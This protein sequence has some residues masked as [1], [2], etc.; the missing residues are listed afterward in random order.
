MKNTFNK[1][2]IIVCTPE[3]LLCNLLHI[4]W[5]NVQNYLII[6]DKGLFFID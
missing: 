5:S 6:S 2:Y 3:D 1:H 4:L